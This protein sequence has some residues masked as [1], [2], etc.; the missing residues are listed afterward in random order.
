VGFTHPLSPKWLLG[1]DYRLAE[2]TDTK[3]TATMPAMAG[4]GLNHVVGMQAIGNNL[5]GVNDVGVVNVNY[6]KGE[7]Y[8]GQAL[9]GNYVYLLGDAWR[10]DLNLRYYR[11]K[12]DLGQKQIRTSPSLKIG[13]RW[14]FV[15]LEAEAGQED[16]KTDGPTFTERS[17]RKYFFLGY[18]LDLR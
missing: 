17:D 14:D 15:T 6:I 18:R 8:N 11:Q 2:I 12:D 3:A 4:S 13:Y 10:F 1:A 16:I 7:T 5:L 9:G